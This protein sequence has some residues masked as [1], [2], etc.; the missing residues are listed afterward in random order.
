M[1]K[2]NNEISLRN[3]IYHTEKE[4]WRQITPEHKGYRTALWNLLSD[5]MYVSGDFEVPADEIFFNTTILADEVLEWIIGQFDFNNPK[6]IIV[7]QPRY[8]EGERVANIV[9]LP[10]YLEQHE[11]AILF[12][13]AGINERV[14]ITEEKERF[15]VA[16]L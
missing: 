16:I 15:V 2:H 12:H 8:E 4:A 5:N 7:I 1:S 9:D 6:K 14:V 3:L 10:D 11:D 13:E